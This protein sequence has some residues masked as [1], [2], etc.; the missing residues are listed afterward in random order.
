MDAPLIPGNDPAAIDARC[1]FMHSADVELD[2]EIL[3]LCALID[4]ASATAAETIA[5]FGMNAPEGQLAQS[6][7]DMLRHDLDIMRGPI[8]YQVPVRP[9][10]SS[11][12]HPASSI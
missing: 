9:Q 3:R 12:Q 5:I 7:C 10:S 6:L 2:P 4:H 1:Q 11:I 8:P